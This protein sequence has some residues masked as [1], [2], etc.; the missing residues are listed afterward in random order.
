MYGVYRALMSIFAEFLWEHCLEKFLHMAQS[1]NHSYIYAGTIPTLVGSIHILS[2]CAE[3]F[4]TKFISVGIFPTKFL[5]V[6]YS[7]TASAYRMVD[8]CL[9]LF[10]WLLSIY[11]MNS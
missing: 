11:S 5:N 1:R 7:N 10:E 3:I 2:S 9:T 8:K 6:A 4:F